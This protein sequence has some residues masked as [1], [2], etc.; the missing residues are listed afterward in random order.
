MTMT[1]SKVGAYDIRCW[2]SGSGAPLLY[3]HGFE[4]HPGNAPYLQKLAGKRKV[5]AP[6]HP[7][8]GESTGIEDLQHIL[9]VALHYRQLVE[10]WGQGPVDVIGHSLGGMFAAEFAA[11]SPH[12]VRKLVLVSPY[13]LWLDDE[14]APDP[15]VLPADVMAKAKWHD[16]A[17]AAAETSAFTDTEKLE[18]AVFRAKNLGSATKF[19]WPIPDRGLGRRLRY[20]KAP[21]LVV[22]GETDGLVSAAYAQA[23]AEGIG[24]AKT[25]SIAAAGHLPMVEQEAAFLKVVEDFLA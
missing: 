2:T 7:G 11:V 4:Q 14:P 16:V 17:S 20:I 23:F 21:T 10:D 5:I 12:L 18:Q 22:R 24:G 3:L 6:E 19:M 15:F 9:D 8:F 1:M 13:G 25:A